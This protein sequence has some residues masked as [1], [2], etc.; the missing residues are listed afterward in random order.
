MILVF[1][2]VS[3]I[4]AAFSLNSSDR[5]ASDETSA[6]TSSDKSIS[7]IESSAMTSSLDSTSSAAPEGLLSFGKDASSSFFCAGSDVIFL[8]FFVESGLLSVGLTTG[9]PNLQRHFEGE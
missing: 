5:S 4:V 2:A 1:T 7:S 8:T 3:N 6:L 9:A